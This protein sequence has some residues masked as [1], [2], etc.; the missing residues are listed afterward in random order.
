M[1]QD[2]RE[3]EKW[4]RKAADQGHAWAQTNLGFMYAVG[5]G[6]DKDFV[7]AYAWMNLA[8]AQGN[9]EAAKAKDFLKSRMTSEELNMAP[10]HSAEILNRIESSKLE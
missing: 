4:F 5:E 8:A 9:A 3:V 2:D 10:D 6:V 1:L 7:E